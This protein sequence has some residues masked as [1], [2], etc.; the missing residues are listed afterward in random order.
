[1]HKSGKHWVRTV[2]TQIGLMNIGGRSTSVPEK[3]LLKVNQ[4]ESKASDLLRGLIA[5][6]TLVG[7]GLTVD[8][9]LAEEV[10]ISSE[11]TT[12]IL[13]VED[14]VVMSDTSTDLDISSHSISVSTSISD[15]ESLSISNSSS[16][17]VVNSESESL[18][19]SISN[20]ESESLSESISNSESE[21]LSESI[22]NSESESL[23]ESISISNSTSNSLLS[24]NSTKASDANSISIATSTSDS[25]V[26]S[27]KIIS[28][29]ESISG[30]DS[31]TTNNEVE[32]S[33]TS[34]TEAQAT[35]EQVTSEAEILVQIANSQ[36]GISQELE[37]AIVSS[38]NEIS[39]AKTLLGN[40]SASLV[41]LQATISSLQA[42]NQSLGLLLLQDDEDGIITFAL[43]TT[44]TA[45]LKVG[46]GEGILVD[47]LSTAS[48]EMT[49]AKGAK[50][51]DLTFLSPY[52][53][54]SVA[55]WHTFSYTATDTYDQ[56]HKSSG[57]TALN[58]YIRYSLDEDPST[59]TVLAELVSK[60]GT[61]LESYKIDP[62]SSATFTYP[63]TLDT[64]N[65]PITITYDTSLATASGIP[66]GLR[67]STSSA[68]VYG[69]TLV[70]TYTLNTTYYK[71]TDGT[72]IA[73]YSVM[74]IGGQT[75]TPSGNR[76]F[77]GY[78]YSTT[79]NATST[80]ALTPGTT[81]MHGK[82]EAQGTK[83]LITVIDDQGTIKRSL[84]YRDPTYTGTV[85]W[86][87]TDTTGFIKLFETS[88]IAASTSTSG[89]NYNTYSTIEPSYTTT[90]YNGQRIMVFYTSP[91]KN[92]RLIGYWTGGTGTGGT[93]Y[94]Q[95]YF[96]RQSLDRAG[97]WGLW[98]P[99]FSSIG[100]GDYGSQYVLGNP[101]STLVN[102]TTHWYTVDTSESE[103]LS[104][105]NSHSLSESESTSNSESASNSES[106]SNSESLS[107]SES[108][109]NSE[110]LSNSISE[111]VR[112]SVSESISE[113][114]SE[115][116]S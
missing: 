68:N 48:P 38:I 69:T 7:G 33:T 14:T 28:S 47:T 88:E 70:P 113:S 55:G 31:E 41:E 58:A 53:G 94:G 2:M 86:N 43:N 83:T 96:G 107:N 112:E 52:A 20:S 67:F 89:T 22:S 18:S 73:T 87:G 35:L 56:N 29:S 61:V 74:T 27:S 60:T 34:V 21:S 64:D 24:S 5:A 103:S 9:A 98:K 95:F 82:V 44:T 85:D 36:T 77:V 37:N 40:S 72:I 39:S 46:E 110:S 78:D 51:T 100:V 50:V 13:A 3:E 109:S 8:Q 104:N 114:V 105:S 108:T 4:P 97:N 99:N 71:T 15:L 102:E 19:E 57:G 63:S 30:S 81:Y 106:I 80:R 91:A 92:W 79:T 111:S 11:I 84:Y 101:L 17:S 116:I 93:Q 32:P 16:L 10:A 1:M 62:G 42:S 66:G 54:T 59:Y 65:S 75:V 76:S 23:S 90:T 115:S 45:T 12:T 25:E 49:D 26:A 6:G